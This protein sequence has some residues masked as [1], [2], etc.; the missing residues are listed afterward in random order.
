MDREPARQRPGEGR[1]AVLEQRLPVEP[2]RPGQRLLEAGG[3]TAG[4]GQQHVDQRLPRR[5]GAEHVQPAADLGVLDLAEVPVHAQQEMVEIVRYVRNAEVAVEVGAA[6][7][8]P[9]ALLDERQLGGIQRLRLGVL[10]HQLLD[11]DDR[12]VG[13]GRAHRRDQVI[14]D[15]RVGASLRLGALARVV[16]HERVEERQ[17]GD[18]E[19]GEAARR[20]SQRL[21]RQ[22]FGGPVL[23]EMHHRVDPLD[24][25]QEP[26]E[27]EVV[28]RRCQV[29][30]VVDGG[31]ILAEAAWRLDDDQHLAEAQSRE[32]QRVM[33]RV[34]VTRRL[35]PAAPQ[36]RLRRCGN[37]VDE[38]RI[39]RQFEPAR[40][41]VELGRRQVLAVV[42][43]LVDQR[44]HQRVAVGGQRG[45]AEVVAVGAERLQQPHRR[46]GSVETDGVAD[47]GVAARIAAEDDR[48]ALLD[49]AGPVQ[50]GEPRRQP[51]QHADALDVRL[52][53]DAAVDRLFE[54]DR[55]GDD[56]AVELRQGDVHHRV[57]R[58]EAGIAGLPAG[59]RR[60]DGDRL[61]NGKAEPL[62]RLH[63]PLGG[64]LRSAG[65]QLAHGEGQRAD[66]RVAEG[67]TIRATEVGERGRVVPVGAQ[68]IAEDGQ[69][70]ASR[71]LERADQGVDDGEVAAHPVGPV[72]EHA[73]HRPVVA[74]VGAPPPRRRS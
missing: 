61:E 51:G 17:V 39:R 60:A 35:P 48:Q 74:K 25:A 29:G 57:D 54:G 34:E 72:E 3:G 2:R 55:H 47:A 8:L 11:D 44:V 37:G 30:R 6:H 36:L 7:R 65:G 40:G 58:G 56:P 66:H 41:R 45:A 64:H 18:A 12:A 33:A 5:R 67:A 38:G 14:D 71:L 69:R 73:D 27:A 50:P 49:V 70:S 22:P 68:R 24:V 26:V 28:M 32:D 15:D 46:G 31:G 16:D 42:R 1:A 13:L 23:A 21:S 43:T 53:A 62:Q 20:Q 4:E 10:V 59:A 9:D 63:R 19:V 52:V